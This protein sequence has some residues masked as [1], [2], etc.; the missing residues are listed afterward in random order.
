M[1]SSTWWTWGIVTAV[2]P[3][4]V[5]LDGDTAAL[6]FTPTALILLAVG[7]R[8]R[9]EVTGHRVIVHGATQAASGAR[10]DPSL[11]RGGIFYQLG[12]PT[13]PA[14]DGSETVVWAP[15]PV[16][17]PPGR[18]VRL[19]LSVSLSG[20]A[21]N[22]QWSARLRVGTGTAGQALVTT[23]W[24]PVGQSGLGSNRTWTQHARNSSSAAM[25]RNLVVTVQAIN[26]YAS[27]QG[28]SAGWPWALAIDDI[29]QA[30]GVYAASQAIT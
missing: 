30:S 11:P 24:Q 26:G 10:Q 27:I 15:G 25:A 2:N 19:H 8:V 23:Y 22:T 7:D 3:L 17:F 14:A 9:C 1:N 16:T 18:A 5:Q 20:S 4:R 28:G 13:S 21:A 29:G 6:P 12:N